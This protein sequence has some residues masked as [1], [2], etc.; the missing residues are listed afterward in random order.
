MKE[1]HGLA[2]SSHNGWCLVKVT[3]KHPIFVDECYSFTP[4]NLLFLEQEYV[5]SNNQ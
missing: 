4:D 1:A 3:P 5:R 2:T